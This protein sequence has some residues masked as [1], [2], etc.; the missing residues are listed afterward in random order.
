MNTKKL[1]PL[2]LFLVLSQT[3]FAQNCGEPQS[4]FEI[5]GAN[6]KARILNA[7]DLFSDLSDGQFIPNPGPIGSIN[8]TTIYAAGLW[9]GGLDSG[10]N[11]RLAAAS[12]RS[13]GN[14]FFTGPLDPATG[15]TDD[16]T[17]SNWDRHFF[18]T[19]AEIAAFLNNPPQNA[20]ELISQYPG[21]ARW[22]GRGNPYFAGQ[23][24]FDLPFTTQALAPFYDADNN[25]AY[26]PLSGD[27]P[28]VQLR[29]QPFFVPDQL[30]WCI[31]NDAGGFHSNTNGAAFN[32]E[33]QLTV[34]TFDCSDEAF[35]PVLNNTVFTSHKII[36]RGAE[37]V[38]S[39]FIGIWTDVD[40]GCY[41]DDYV[42][43]N[44]DLHTMFAYNQDAVDGQP[45]TFCAGGVP[46]FGQTPPVQS[47]TFLSHSLDKF[48]P[49]NNT[50]AAVPPGTTDPNTPAEYYNYLSGSWKDG[51]PLTDAPNGYSA[52]NPV[53]HLYPSDPA[54]PAG[55]SMCTANLP[56]GDRRMLGNISIG[57]LEPGQIEEIN[58]AWAF[59]P[60]PELPCGLGSTFSDVQTLRATYEGGFQDVCSIVKAP[61]L[62][63]DSLKLFPNPTADIAILKYGKI[64]PTALRA[65]DAAGRLVMEKNGN[66]EKEETRIQT[67]SLASGIYTLQIVT[68]QGTAIKKLTVMR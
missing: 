61:D 52:G 44:P 40:L 31:F 67:G 33:I 19:G 15:S 36:A 2:L 66:F 45:G 22:P 9:M 48:I 65:Y 42:G 68:P 62:P 10:G 24:G 8:P 58:V 43:C 20:S 28:V 13:D 11:L 46:T 38:D 50:G 23:W 12:Y 16:F 35:L 7:G 37:R 47:V 57:S 59:H 29:G 41:E 27:Y 51:S 1:L 64:I 63:A 30:V 54:D 39:V 56:G 25:G 17:C 4:Q 26:N 6:L 55:W 3:N 49:Y 60:N 21:I 34:W 18:V 14:D 32:T 53:D 5:E